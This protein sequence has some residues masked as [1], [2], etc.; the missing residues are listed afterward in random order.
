MIN[1]DDRQ[2]RALARERTARKEAEHLLEE[3]SLALYN[4][5][6]ALQRLANSLE[7]QVSDRTAELSKALEKAQASTRAKSDFLAMMSHEIRTPM[8]GILG[9]TQLMELT[10]LNAEQRS[11]L[12][13]VRSSG[14][15]LLVLINDILDLSKVE[16]GKLEL[17]DNNFRLKRSLN[18]SL[19]LYLPIAERKGLQL[20]M[21]IAHD[22]PD[23][24]RGD[25]ARLR[26]ILGNLTNNAIKFTAKGQV[27]IEVSV[28]NSTASEVHLGFTVRDTGI[29]IPSG[30]IHRLFQPFSQVDT[31]TT[32]QYGGSGLGLAICA[33]LCASMRG[34]ITV[35]SH[36]GKG[37]VFQFDV[38]LGAC[39]AAVDT[40]P[41]ELSPIGN[42]RNTCNIL[43]VDDDLVNR[44]MA[45]AMLEKIGFTAQSASSGQEAIDML[46]LNHFD[47]VLMD[48]Q[49]PGMNG[50]QATQAIRRHECIRQ[51]HI[52]ALTANA[53]ESDR[54]LCLQSGMD[55]FLSKPL[56]LTAMREK[57][58]NLMQAN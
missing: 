52:I 35:D 25:S 39:V 51:P 57:L 20:K 32:R 54:Q 27:L 55:D 48:M 33:R 9:M 17:E 4:A 13:I 41:A 5:N 23:Q 30:R 15:A 36:E 44:T 1:P 49:M 11:Y 34:S 42:C 43:V 18:D 6:Q 37:S 56:R 26:Q 58:V 31:S 22:V 40:V 2:A 10:T 28:I 29:G 12:S 50:V 19:A 7:Q 24:V 21:H 8:N 45:L 14:D 38:R 16:A 46:S 3:K 47:I 53:Y